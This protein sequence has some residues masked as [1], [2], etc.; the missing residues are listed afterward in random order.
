MQ[1]KP[2]VRARRQLIHTGIFHIEEMDLEFANGQQRAYQRIVGS[3][4][5]AVLAVPLLDRETVLLI[6]EY[7]AS[8]LVCL[9][10]RQEAVGRPL[11]EA[12]ATG[13]PVVATRVGAVPEIVGDAATL[14]TPDDPEALAFALLQLLDASDLWKQRAARA[15]GRAS[16]FAATAAAAN[17]WPI[18]KRCRGDRQERAR[19]SEKAWVQSRMVVTCSFW[20]SRPEAAT[21]R[22]TDQVDLGGTAMGTAVM[23]EKRSAGATPSSNPKLLGWLEEIKTMLK[24]DAVRWCDGCGSRRGWLASQ[25]AIPGRG[26]NP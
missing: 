3:D 17:C 21:A 11:L 12:M 6:R 22:F 4:L 13:R 7:A 5:G 8:D 1:K 20:A 10:C 14:V 15:L 19:G 2:T 16:G 23:E 24:P 26:Q 9:A 25:R 18:S